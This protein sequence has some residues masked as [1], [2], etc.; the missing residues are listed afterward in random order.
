MAASD[1]NEL[2]SVIW[3]E[4]KQSVNVPRRLLLKGNQAAIKRHLISS[5]Q[6]VTDPVP[7]ESE[8]PAV[9]VEQVQSN[10]ELDAISARL[11]ALESAP[12]PAPLPTDQA[13]AAWSAQAARV[14]MVH[15]EMAALADQT[16]AKVEVAATAANQR[17]DQLDSQQEAQLQAI[18]ESLSTTRDE[19]NSTVLAAQAELAGFMSDTEAAALAKAEE[20]AAK[21]RGPRG[22]AGISSVTCSED[23]LSAD[24]SWNGRWLGR[25]PMIGDTAW[26]VS[27]TGITFRRHVH[28]FH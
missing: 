22:G 19:V 3:N 26:V 24:D 16:I 8:E 14:S 5:G 15:A 18:S 13:L 1:P 21:Q 10:G 23:P 7:S 9:I 25:N 11:S 2:V 20:I 4:T 12:G 27:S 17:I 6:L 28:I